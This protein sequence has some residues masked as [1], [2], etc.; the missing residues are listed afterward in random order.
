[1]IIE[2]FE[3]SSEHSHKLHKHRKQSS[4]NHPKKETMG[5][6]VSMPLP[7]GIKCLNENQTQELMDSVRS[8]LPEDIQNSQITLSY[9]SEVPEEWTTDRVA[10]WVRA[11]SFLSD[12]EIDIIND[13]VRD[14]GIDGYFLINYSLS[15]WFPEE[16]ASVLGQM[17]RRREELLDLLQVDEEEEE[18][19][20]DVG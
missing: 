2:L 4:E 18:E 1:M 6:V 9:I 10:A 3:Q 11:A 17:E 15:T 13:A 7:K 12:N 19:T 20:E 16:C 8:A 5:W 14:I